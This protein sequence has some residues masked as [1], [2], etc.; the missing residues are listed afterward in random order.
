MDVSVKSMQPP[1]RDWAKE[2]AELSASDAALAPEDLERFAT[3]AHLVGEEEQALRLL[4]HAHSAYLDSGASEKAA[5]AAFWLVIHLRYAGQAAQA[6]GWLARL[7]HILDDH[8]PDGKQ[9]YLLLLLEGISLI[10]AGAANEAIPLLELAATGARAA[11]DDD[12][13]VLT[14]LNRGRCLVL[15]GQTP[16]ALATL[17]EIMVDVIAERVAPEIV[18]L[19]YC[20]VISLC[21][22]RFDIQRAGEWTRALTGWCAAQSGLMPYRGECQ[23]HR[24]EIFQ[25][26]GSW[27]AATEE[28]GQVSRRLATD[29]LVAGA[30]HYRLAELH[31]LQDQLNLAD[32]EYAVAA[33]CGCEVQPG[34][35]LL[36]LAQG[37]PAVGI[38]GLDRALA[39][40]RDPAKRSLLLAAKVEVALA[41]GTIDAARTAL[42]E[43]EKNADTI[44]TPY[45]AALVAH[46]AGQL[47][48]AE[49]DP[50][51]ALPLLRR[52]WA[53]WQQ[54]D[55]PYEAARTRVQVSAA[56]LALGD[57]DAA[58]MELDAA[59]TVFEQLGAQADL[60]SLAP[61]D[62]A[63]PGHPLTARE[64][65]VLALVAQGHTNRRI[66][67]ILFLSE[68]TVA[69][70]LSNIFTKIDV[71]SRAAATAYAYEHGL[72]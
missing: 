21:M 15:L 38:A 54:V 47:R 3:A 24:A 18:G 50:Q 53:L 10:Q 72:V 25:L 52:A 35:A 59:R 45:M 71:N 37:K 48:L 2:Y 12:I 44:E 32:R 9:S 6:A 23:V 31:R 67:T 8:D 34:L 56:C 49:D 19:A 64:C 60:V 29:G 65:E 55:A 43:L 46:A 63:A 1:P 36:R 13:F 33:G 16:A 5:R 40:S 69:R 30:A 14:G 58:R 42:A 66:A 26:H 28:A 62:G 20:S 61:T 70:H 22:E 7:R 41:A 17:D 68:K 39:E 11:K 27:A 51:A 4:D 57:D